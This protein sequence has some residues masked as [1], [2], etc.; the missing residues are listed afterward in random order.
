[1]FQAEEINILKTAPQTPRMNA[2]RERIIH[3]LRHE[4]RDHVLIINQACECPC[5]PAPDHLPATL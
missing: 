5:P 4:M 3:T 2:H 1:V